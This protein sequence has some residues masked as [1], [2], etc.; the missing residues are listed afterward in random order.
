MHVIFGLSRRTIMLYWLP[1]NLLEWHSAAL[2]I[3][4]WSGLWFD[5]EQMC[6]WVNGEQHSIL[7]TVMRAIYH[8]L[9]L[10]SK[11]LYPECV[12]VSVEKHQSA[13]CTQCAETCDYV[14]ITVTAQCLYVCITAE[15]LS[16]S[17]KCIATCIEH[18]TATCHSQ[19]HTSTASQDS[20]TDCQ[21]LFTWDRSQ[22]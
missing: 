16:V 12:F 19:V 7:E 13:R 18:L 22:Y 1:K 20:A 9:F 17:S 14:K 6:S 15:W 21:R 4:L 11:F 2:W 8:C 5:I 3:S 10:C